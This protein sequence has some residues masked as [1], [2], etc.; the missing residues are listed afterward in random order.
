METTPEHVRLEIVRLALS[1][2]NLTRPDSS[3]RSPETF[4][5][6]Y[7]AIAA[8]VLPEPPLAPELQGKE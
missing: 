6:W 7:D 5:R 1:G 4:T 3:S 8:K 2:M